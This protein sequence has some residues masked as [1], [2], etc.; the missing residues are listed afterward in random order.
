MFSLNVAKGLQVAEQLYVGGFERRDSVRKLSFTKCC[1]MHEST[2]LGMR[3]DSFLH[4]H[5]LARK[6][7]NLVPPL[8]RVTSASRAHKRE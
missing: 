3:S 4:K 7:K 2:D 6:V 8:R 5:K 1:R